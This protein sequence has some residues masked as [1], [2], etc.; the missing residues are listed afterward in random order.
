MLPASLNGQNLCVILVMHRLFCFGDLVF[1]DVE[2]LGT[3]LKSLCDKISDHFEPE[4]HLL[5]NPRIDHLDSSLRCW[6]SYKY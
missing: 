4:L 2:A 5:V 1:R 6:V 3:A